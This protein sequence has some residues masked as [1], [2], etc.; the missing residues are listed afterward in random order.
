MSTYMASRLA[1]EEVV[2]FSMSRAFAFMAF[3]A[4]TTRSTA[5]MDLSKVGLPLLLLF[6]RRS[7]ILYYE[8]IDTQS[9]WSTVKKSAN[10]PV[11]CS[12]TDPKRFIGWEPNPAAN[13]SANR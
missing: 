8:T 3:A 9:T 12:A 13:S 1:L 6:Y 10:L 4:C 5:F 7:C 2:A 11:I